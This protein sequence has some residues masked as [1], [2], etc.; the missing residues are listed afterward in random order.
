MKKKKLYV[1]PELRQ[2]PLRPQ[3]AILGF[4]KV[5]NTRGPGIATCAFPSS[6]YTLGS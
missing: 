5:N 4:C 3:E 6:C 1:K 2:V